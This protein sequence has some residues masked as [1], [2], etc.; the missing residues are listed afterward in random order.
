MKITK[1]DTSRYLDLSEEFTEYYNE[2]YNETHNKAHNKV[3]IKEK[4][5]NMTL[6]L[7]FGVEKKLYDKTKEFIQDSEFKNLV[8]KTLI[9]SENEVKNASLSGIFFDEKFARI[10]DDIYKA[11]ENADNKY[12]ICLGKIYYNYTHMDNN[13]LVKYDV[14]STL[15]SEAKWG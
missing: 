6:Y 11:E 14:I 13:F 9:V 5:P 3:N 15:P 4:Y 1:D 12:T 7:A 8:M 2:T 10:L